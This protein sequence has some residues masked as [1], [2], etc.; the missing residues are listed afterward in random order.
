[1]FLGLYIF[2]APS[3]FLRQTC[4]SAA[5]KFPVLFLTSTNGVLEKIRT[6][7]LHFKI[8]NFNHYISA[9]AKT[10]TNVNKICLMFDSGSKTGR[11]E[12]FPEALQNHANVGWVAERKSVEHL[13]CVICSQSFGCRMY[14]TYY[15]KNTTYLENHANFSLVSC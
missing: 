6:R 10:V 11:R 1:M 4:Y 5:F 2:A 3:L 12:T 14:A 13:Q 7:V 15:T 8:L 9:A